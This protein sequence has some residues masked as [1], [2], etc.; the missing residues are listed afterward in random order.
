MLLLGV[1]V[2]T[3]LYTVYLDYIFNYSVCWKCS[4]VFTF[5][6]LGIGGMEAF[7]GLPL[8]CIN[9]FSPWGLD[10]IGNNSGMIGMSISNIIGLAMIAYC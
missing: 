8:F 6:F 2:M 4:L 3:Q 1:V 9:W 5:P 10:N 7:G